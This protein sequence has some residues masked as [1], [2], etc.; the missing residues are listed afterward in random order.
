MAK[1]GGSDLRART[2]SGS[3]PDEA[4]ER[5]VLGQRGKHPGATARPRNKCVL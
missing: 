3:E 2:S 1:G 4:R 5:I